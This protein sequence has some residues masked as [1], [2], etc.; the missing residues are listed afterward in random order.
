MPVSS[1]QINQMMGAQQAMFG[2][3]ATYAQQISPMGQSMGMA[4]TYAMPYSPM[5]S[6]ATAEFN[7][8][9][10]AAPGM[11]NAAASYGAP[12]MMGAGMM[13]GGRMGAMLDPTT[14]AMRG[15]GTGVGWKS[16][17]GITSN[18]GAVAR[19]GV[20]GIARGAMMGA[21]Y[22][23]PV[24]AMYAAGKYAFGQMAEGAQFQNQ[25]NAVLQNTFRFTNDQSRTGYGFGQQ[26]QRQIGSM[27][28]SMGTQDMMTTP[29]ELLGLVG[30]GAQMGVFRG[31]QDAR[32]F[33]QRF[34]QMKDALKEIAST[35]N[36]TLS[37]AV[38]FFQQARQQGFW[39]PQDITKHA[40]QVRQV[41]ANT[42]MSAQQ[43][44]AVMGMGAQMVRSIGGTGQQ[45]AG[46]MARAQQIS[47]AALFG[48]VVS[49][50]ELGEAGFGTGA[51]GAQNL[52]SMLAG[53]SARFAR[54]RTGRWALA[55]LMN[56]E[57]TGLDQTGLQ[58][59]ASGA[60]SIGEIGSRARRNVS[61][62]RAYQFVGNEGEL[63]G[64]LAEAGPQAS[65]GIV[66]SLVGSRLYGTGGRDKL[67]TRRI[68]QRFMG[69]TARQADMVAKLAKEMPRMMAVQAARTEGSLD[70]QER[71]REQQMQDTYEGFKRRIGQWWKEKISGPLQEVGADF[72]YRV[73]RTWQRFTDRLFGTT[74]R[75]VGLS[76]EA[77]RSMVRSAETGNMAYVNETMGTPQM[78]MR[79]M[80]GGVFG[81]RN[82]G[83][84][85]ARQMMRMGFRPQGLGRAEGGILQRL[86][87]PVGIRFGAEQMRQ[88]QA[89]SRATMG[90]TGDE[91]A[92]AIGYESGGAMR[93]AMRGAGAQQIQNYMRSSE[94]LTLRGR[95]GGIGGTYSDM[96]QEEREEY[97]G[98]ILNRIRSGRAGEQ[99]R[100]MFQGL[101]KRQALGRLMA[102]QGS[103]RGGFTGIGG[104]GTELRV[105]EGQAIRTAVE[106]FQTE[107]IE[108]LAT[109][110]RGGARDAWYDPRTLLA[111]QSGGLVGVPV[112]EQ[113]LEEIKKDSRGERAMRLFARAREL[114]GTNPEEAEQ[115]RSDARDLM[116]RI[117]NDKGISKAAR[118]AAIRL[119]NANDPQAKAIA[120]AAGKAGAG[121]MYGD[122]VAFNEKIKRRRRRMQDQL[123]GEG[124]G[125]L[126]T[127][128][129][130]DKAGLAQAL[131]EAMR[132]TG[133]GA[134][135]GVTG[136]DYVK[137][138]EALARA[139]AAD[140][141]K[142][143]AM[144]NQLQREGLGST[145][146][147]TTLGA[148]IRVNA[149]AK[150]FGLK[151]DIAAGGAISERARRGIRKRLSELGISDK[152]VSRADVGKLI[153]GESVEAVR[154]R[155]EKQGYKKEDIESML[156]EMRGGLTTDE[157]RERGVRRAGA[158][159]ITTM[160]EKVAKRAGLEPGDLAGKLTGESGGKAMVKE[161]QV[162]TQWFS[163]M[164]ANLEYI[165]KQE[166]KEPR[167]DKKTG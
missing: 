5:A 149:E 157:M 50:R 36:T 30:R 13:M 49:S 90:V 66:R 68:I 35:F 42:G 46:M 103:A 73:G 74:G 116:N 99:A 71:Q 52:G 109:T 14:A 147:G 165:A 77:V 154:S 59:L 105:R 31:V 6:P 82:L 60:M 10:A 132:T 117:A 155:L 113:G 142:A 96:D 32:E 53:A 125:R 21:A 92:A 47:G 72:S 122:Q 100:K 85:Q 126:I 84:S 41:Q 143:A 70:A 58:K 87:Q 161:L 93:E 23:A 16:G 3:N 24:M 69:G 78:M 33:K 28:H 56:R 12:V 119:G 34:T 40:T 48:G 8:G 133:S 136:Q 7:Q 75:G 159:G 144:M 138:M 83:F 148:A 139:A 54:S 19:G 163:K 151:E 95:M 101:N 127:A 55:A 106:D 112:T 141:D 22:A 160:S 140:P 64:Q 98:K 9:A 57:G 76:A 15:F 79:D 131:Q 114:E 135:G 145:D 81:G 4:P 39:T 18:L 27:L 167:K 63:R 17:A 156:G 111:A 67:V 20:G 37:E 107:T 1:L 102:M 94:V 134:G 153:R 11:F 61:G 44:Q 158:L 129:G 80:G 97:A 124:M 91:E 65:L 162:H 26:E 62:G 146:I 43:A 25:T 51:E 128:A 88:M 166:K 38:P 29:Q 45:G 130:G 86:V 121:L 123:G 150:K 2:N 89:L 164:N 104:I 137:R 115:A 118:S 110:L 120:D 152:D 108:D